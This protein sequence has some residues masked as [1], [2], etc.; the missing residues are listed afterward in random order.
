MQ[1]RILLL[2]LSFG[3]MMLQAQT[4]SRFYQIAGQVVESANGKNIPYATISLLGDSAKVLKRVISDLNGKFLL[5]VNE[6]RTYIVS[7]SFMGFQEKKVNVEIINPKTDLGQIGLAEG[8][9]MQEVSV[10]AQKPLVKVDPDKLTYNV[11]ADPE[12][13][14]SNALE[15]L[16]KVPLVTVDAEDNV[17]VNGKSDFKVLVNGK[18]SS[19]MSNN[20]KEVI[21]SIPAN[22]IKNIE[23]ITNPSSKYEAEGVG[24]I[25]NIITT[26]KKTS[27]YNGSVNAGFDSQGNLNAGVYL[28][29]KI[30][31][32]SASVRYSASQY[33]QPENVSISDKTNYLS[34]TYYTSNTSA[35]SKYHGYWSNFSGELGYEIDSLNLISA[36]FWG[37]TGNNRRTSFSTNN[38]LDIN[39]VQSQYFENDYTSNSSYGGFS[40]N[41]DY[42]RTFK[43]PDK[44]F[45]IS[46]KLDNSPNKTNTVTNIENAINYTPY[47]QNSANDAYTRE[48]TLQ[49]DYYD[50]LSSMHQIECGVKGIYRQNNSNSNVYLL[51]DS[52][53][54]WER[55]A[56]KSNNLHYDQDILGAYTGYG[57]KLKNFTAKAGMRVELTWNNAT[58][59]SDTAISFSNRLQNFIPYVNFMYQLRPESS[60]KISY[61]QRL[62]RPGIW[63]L[64]PYVNTTDP[65]NISYGNPNLKSEISHSFEIAYSMFKPKFNLNL[66]GNSAF[67]N[68]SIRSISS[69]NA[70]GVTSTTYRNIGTDFNVGLN[71]YL[72][73][74]PSEK[75]N[76]NF[77][78]DC[79]YVKL[80][81]NNGYTI[82]SSG[83]NYY[84]NLSS[85]LVLWKNGSINLSGG[86]YVP[87]PE[88]QNKSSLF[89]YSNIGVS[90]SFLD[91]KMTLNMS[92]SNP[93]LRIRIF[94]T[95]YDD[96]YYTM[97][98]E[99]SYHCRVLRFNVTY[100]FGKSDLEVKKAKRGIQNDD[101]KSGNG[102]S[103]GGGGN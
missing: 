33:R 6:K 43:K 57:F 73:F 16:R 45:T 100:N 61:T 82:S 50:P 46:Y 101:V 98:T 55:S 24:G 76:I 56:S 91:K 54:T 27:G 39:G 52:T 102:N 69:I 18:S 66:S 62:S 64:N 1:K 9:M 90:H 77:N 3:V 96:P 80:E 58:S 51:N 29:A 23:V 32:F 68:N 8:V 60:I 81:A 85:R 41:I 87:G 78:G 94:R 12:A 88:L 49:I 89:Y 5:S 74:R 11:D 14:T 34:N 36:S 10:V 42:Q 86:L 67:T 72:S 44:T 20:F 48:Q 84:G 30:N 22:T 38:T 40:G 25:I 75:F 79:Y 21:K 47:Q 37:Y 83:M 53:D 31:K 93:F 97:H 2:F 7:V 99:D 26:Q 71:M 15:M 65:L 28:A 13:S 92:L 59:I 70:L 19:M 4:K 103:G 95:T 35:T 63:Y 17:M